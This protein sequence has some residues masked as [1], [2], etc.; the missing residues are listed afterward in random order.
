MLT[1]YTENLWQLELET[2]YNIKQFVWPWIFKIYFIKKMHL[3]LINN[4]IP[5]NNN[6][7]KKV[8]V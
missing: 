3:P 5:E 4:S 6:L 7:I 2:Y 8:K 1:A